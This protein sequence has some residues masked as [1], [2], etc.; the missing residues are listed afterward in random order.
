M[1]ERLKSAVRSVEAPAHLETRIRA[2][3][4]AVQTPK[5]RAL[6]ARPWA[7]AAA[8]AVVLVSGTIAYELGHLRLTTSSQ[9]SYIAK[10][11]MQVGTLMRV[12]LGDHVHCAV[13]RKY[14]KN[15]PKVE[16][17]EAKLGPEYAGLIPILRSK[18]SGDYR[19]TIGHQCRYHDRKFVHLSMQGEGRLLSVVVARKGEGESFKTEQLVPALV[20]AG[21]PIYQAGVQRFELAA[22]ESR[23]HMVY[24]IS[25]LPKERNTELMV[26]LAPQVKALLQKLEL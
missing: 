13:F 19:L 21:I 8:A 6:W 5:P 20:Q 7:I 17:L 10:V 2:N 22:F 9:E 26:A 18:V 24:V 1:N 12:G 25:D 23:D 15:P 14:P 16:E 4:H 11:T 3:L